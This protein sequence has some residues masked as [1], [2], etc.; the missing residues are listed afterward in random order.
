MGI[1]KST[2]QMICPARGPAMVSAKTLL[3]LATK[4]AHPNFFSLTVKTNV[5]Q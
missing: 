1:V 5:N 3:S 2:V 4:N